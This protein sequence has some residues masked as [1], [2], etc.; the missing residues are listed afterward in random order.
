V[1]STPSD[2]RCA[3]RSI[4]QLGSGAPQYGAAAAAPAGAAAPPPPALAAATSLVA[5]PAAAVAAGGEVEA[6]ACPQDS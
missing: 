2:L 1:S 3:S 6:D 5:A 4:S